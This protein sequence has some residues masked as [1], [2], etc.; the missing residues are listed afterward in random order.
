[1][2][3]VENIKR[4]ILLAILKET[5]ALNHVKIDNIAKSAHTPRTLVRDFIMEFSEGGLLKIHNE[6][7]AVNGAQR[8]KI[9]LKAAE[10]GSDIERI[11]RFLTWSE[12][13]RFS[14]ISFEEKGFIVK[15]N[16]RFV[17]L[18]KRW[19]IDILGVKRPIVISADCKHWQ[20]KWSGTA[21]LR[22][23][24]MQVERT[25]ALA[26]ASRRLAGKIG[27]KGWR[28]AYFVPIV[29]SLFPSQHKFHE[30]T[31]IVPILSLNDF[32]QNVIAHLDDINSFYIS[33]A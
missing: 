16:F 11:A 22:A 12:F 33:Y 21:S 13:E 1:M 30:R 19:E 32:L 9:A 14:R 15:M 28:Y 27:I 2:S 4:E 7:I 31:P 17:W 29:L 24:E 23:V 5:A 6:T 3:A 10:L 8:L 25:K 18:S 26:E 20:R